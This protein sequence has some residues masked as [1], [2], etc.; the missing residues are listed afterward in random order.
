MASLAPDESFIMSTQAWASV[1][2]LFTIVLRLL[3]GIDAI[4]WRRPVHQARKQNDACI[5]G[6]VPPLFSTT[7]GRRKWVNW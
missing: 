5:L 4:T 1:G 6:G 7:C 3:K 2:A